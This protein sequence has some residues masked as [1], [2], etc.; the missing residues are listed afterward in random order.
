MTILP[1]ISLASVFLAACVSPSGSDIDTDTHVSPD[2]GDAQPPA[3]EQGTSELL[4]ART[5]PQLDVLQTKPSS[6]DFVTVTYKRLAGDVNDRIAVALKGSP[7]D[8]YLMS[9]RTEGATSGTVTFFHIPAGAYEIRAY[10]GDS[11]LL[12]T[13]PLGLTVQARNASLYLNQDQYGSTDPIVVDYSGMGLNAL[14]WITVA[15]ADA[16][17]DSSPE[18]YYTNGNTRGEM[19]FGAVPAGSYE[20]RAF[21]D[22]R[23]ERVGTLPFVVVD[24]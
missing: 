5:G 8:E 7:T 15:P 9:E 23:L 11:F 19:T 2:V 10:R 3:L 6:G 18:W 12:Q 22:G 17:D 16:P 20:V 1:R 24:P 14:D 4:V 13:D 21:V